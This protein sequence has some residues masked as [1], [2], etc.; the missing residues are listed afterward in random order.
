MTIMSVKVIIQVGM[1][2]TAKKTQSVKAC[3]N[4]VELSWNTGEGGT[5]LTSM[6]D[7]KFKGMTWYMCSTEVEEEDVIKISVKTFLNGVGMDHE[8][9]FESL[10]YADAEAPVREV[11]LRDVGMKNYP[12]IKGRIL[13]I[14]TVSE[15]DKRKADIEEFLNEGF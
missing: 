11:S 4:D 10:Y 14:G 9:T 2:K 5:F 13:E 15:E 3:V 7:R 1:V 12:L 6:K 8:N